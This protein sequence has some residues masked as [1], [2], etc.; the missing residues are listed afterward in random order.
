MIT[1]IFI[2]FDEYAAIHQNRY[3]TEDSDIDAYFANGG[4]LSSLDHDFW[5][6]DSEGF[7]RRLYRTFPTRYRLKDFALSKSLRRVLKKTAI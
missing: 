5:R 4:V 1:R 7:G 3:L 6:N 2:D